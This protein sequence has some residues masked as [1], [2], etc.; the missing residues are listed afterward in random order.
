M[1]RGRDRW[2]RARAIWRMARAAAAYPHITTLIQAGDPNARIHPNFQS[3]RNHAK[4]L[5]HQQLT[6]ELVRLNDNDDK[7]ESDDDDLIAPELR[8]LRAR[9]LKCS[10]AHGSCFGGCRSL[11]RYKF[12][13]GPSSYGQTKFYSPIKRFKQLAKRPK[14]CK[15]G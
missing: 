15:S 2:R 4:D 5:A 6:D 10:S 1:R 9:T 12:R 13:Y 8:R 3:L 14:H 11:R 7:H